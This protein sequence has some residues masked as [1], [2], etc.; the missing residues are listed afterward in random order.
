MNKTT[1]LRAGSLLLVILLIAVLAI[2]TQQEE[3]PCSNP[4]ADISGAIL[5]DGDGDQDALANRAILMR[6]NCEQKPAP[7]PVED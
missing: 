3:D 7:Q 1:V 4:Q 5:A 2:L 6:A